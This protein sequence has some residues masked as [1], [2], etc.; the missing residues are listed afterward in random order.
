[1]LEGLGWLTHW[2]YLP[3]ALAIPTPHML[4]H[5]ELNFLFQFLIHTELLGDLG[6]PPEISIT[7]LREQTFWSTKPKTPKNTEF[8]LNRNI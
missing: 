2:F 3:L 8:S 4:V 7:T 6:S 1:M 5:A